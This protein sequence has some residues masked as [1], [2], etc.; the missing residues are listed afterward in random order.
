MSD[1]IRDNFSKWSFLHLVPFVSFLFQFIFGHLRLKKKK[2][3]WE[4]TDA[5]F[6]VL[7]L[8]V[9]VSIEE[10]NKKRLLFLQSERGEGRGGIEEKWLDET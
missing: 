1:I 5:N 9:T 10:T 4:K 7:H 3:R 2:N 8:S 6:L